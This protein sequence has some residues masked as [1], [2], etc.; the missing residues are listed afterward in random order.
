MLEGAD[1]VPATQIANAMSEFINIVGVIAS[2]PAWQRYCLTTA[3]AERK[4]DMLRILSE[5]TGLQSLL[6]SSNLVGPKAMI[7]RAMV[8]VP[9]LRQLIVEWDGQGQP[10]AVMAAW[11]AGFM[12]GFGMSTALEQE[13]ESPPK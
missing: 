10:S 4:Q 8:A 2:A 11:A 7:R 12:A 3:A 1:D 9:E 5:F 13:R 6:E